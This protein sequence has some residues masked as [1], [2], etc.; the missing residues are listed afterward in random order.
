MHITAARARVAAWIALPIAVVASGSIIATASYAAF[1]ASTDNAGN[2]WTAGKVTITD[3]DNGTALFHVA[4][5]MPGDSGENCITVTADTTDG[6]SVKLYTTGTTDALGL[7]D[8]IQV[9]VERGD[10]SGADCSTFSPTESVFTGTLAALTQKNS[11]GDG[12]GAWTTS[13][14]SEASTYRIHYA[15]DTSADNSVQQATAETTF[16]WEA[17]Q[18]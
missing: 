10:R 8:A 17:Q 1:S 14:S 11:F 6:A 9:T 18:R 7:G 16:V 13:A 12:V 4:D 15:M 3:D 2:T 5:L